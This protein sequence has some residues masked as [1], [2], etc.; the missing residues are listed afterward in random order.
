MSILAFY[1]LCAAAVVLPSVV[2]VVCGLYA[3]TTLREDE[4][5]AQ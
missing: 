3:G 1:A 2:V 4:E 5:A